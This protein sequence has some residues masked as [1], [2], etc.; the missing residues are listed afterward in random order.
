[1]SHEIED[2]SSTFPLDVDKVLFSQL[3]IN[4]LI[5]YINYELQTLHFQ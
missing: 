3:Y 2:N 5:L 1:M 4:L